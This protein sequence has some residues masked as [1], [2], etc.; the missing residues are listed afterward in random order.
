MSFLAIDLGQHSIKFAKSSENNA[1]PEH[2]E[3]LFETLIDPNNQIVAVGN[4]AIDRYLKRDLNTPRGV[5][6]FKEDLRE[7]N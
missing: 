4:D 1:Q 6:L 5:R 7:K 2:F 3:I